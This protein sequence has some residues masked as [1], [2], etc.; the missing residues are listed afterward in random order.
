MS[1]VASSDYDLIVGGSPIY[2]DEVLPSMTQF[3]H[4]NREA[5]SEKRIVPFFVYDR[6]LQPREML[7]SRN[8]E[9]L[10]R[11]GKLLRERGASAGN[12]MKLVEDKLA[13][14]SDAGALTHALVFVFVLLVLGFDSSHFF[15]VA[16]QLEYEG[17]VARL[18]VGKHDV[19]GTDSD[20]HRRN[21]N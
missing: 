4:D 21:P 7:D 11:F 9:D 13:E 2:T 19:R 17:S 1:D 15:F 12:A 16:G 8:K 20:R 14:V 3:L 10:M 6:P 18:H 5:L